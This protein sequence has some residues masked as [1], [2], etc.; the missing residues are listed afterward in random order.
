[1]DKSAFARQHQP[2]V[3]AA[4]RP[5]IRA[6]HLARCGILELEVL[7]SARDAKEI[8]QTREDL[9]QAL[10][11]A[12]IGQVDFDRAASVMYLLAQSGL[13][14]SM[15]VPDLI[16]AAVAERQE[17]TILHYDKDFDRIAQVTGQSTEWVVP[18]GSVP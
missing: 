11:L 3:A 8:E 9:S 7:F 6:G 16:L 15:P 1:V 14:R 17:L 2:S 5:L 13:H 12:E 4:L 18:R 10:V